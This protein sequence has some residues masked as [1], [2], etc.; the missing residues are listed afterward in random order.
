MEY[1]VQKFGVP[2]AE[3]VHR[4]E[5]FESPPSGDEDASLHLLRLYGASKVEAEGL[6]DAT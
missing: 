6:L 1:V 4:L 5:K 2:W 3:W